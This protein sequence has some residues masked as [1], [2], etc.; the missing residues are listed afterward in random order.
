MF[1]LV[2]MRPHLFWFCTRAAEVG[3]VNGLFSAEGIP[4]SA[5][6]ALGRERARALFARSW[7]SPRQFLPFA[8][9]SRLGH[10]LAGAAGAF[11][12]TLAAVTFS[13]V[14]ISFTGPLVLNHPATGARWQGRWRVFR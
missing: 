6:F 1:S 14:G 7:F 9:E 10:F 8:R 2:I 5:Q 11:R 13:F 4:L 12:A 3:F